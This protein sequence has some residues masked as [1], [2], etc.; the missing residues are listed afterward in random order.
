MADII[1]D[2][3]GAKFT[4]DTDEAQKSIQKLSSSINGLDRALKLV[5]FGVFLKGIKS[6]ASAGYKA[7]TQMNNYIETMNLFRATMGNSTQAATEF[8]NKA[9]KVLGLDSSMTMNS[10]AMLQTLAE[11][12]GLANEEAYIMSQNLTQLAAD[13]SSFLNISFEESLGKLKSGLAGEVKAMRNVGVALDRATLQETMYRLGIDQTYASLTRAQKTEL[14]YYQIM[15]STTKMQGDLARTM[16]SPQNAIRILQ[17][18][19]TRLA[20]AIG[21]IF[22][23]IALKIIPVVRAVTQILIEA[24]Q[25]LAKF[26]GFN[27]GD[28]ESDISNVG[29]LLS[30]ISDDIDDVGTS[31]GKAAKELN[32]MLM[33]FDELNNITL[34]SPSAGGIGGTGVGGIGG[35]L[36]IPLPEY[37]MFAGASDE[38]AKKIENI[39]TKIKEL[40]GL[41]G[42]LALA[43]ANV[44]VIKKIIDVIGAINNAKKALELFSKTFPGLSKALRIGTGLVLAIE[45]VWVEYNYAKKLIQG[46]LSIGTLLM[47]T[48]N[49]LLAGIGAALLTGSGEIGLIAGA[50]VL[51]LNLGLAI[52]VKLTENEDFMEV[53]DQVLKYFNPVEWG[54]SLG[55]WIQKDETLDQLNEIANWINNHFNPIMWGYNFTEWI[56]NTDTRQKLEDIHTFLYTYFR[57]YQW[58]YDFT[59]WIRNTDARQ[60][61]ED[62]HTFLYNNFQPYQWGYDFTEW[63]KQDETQ[64]KL[65]EIITFINNTFNPLMWGYNFGEWVKKPETQQKLSEIADWINNHF[66]PFMWGYNLVQWIREGDFFNTASRVVN[67]IIEWFNPW[68]WGINIANWFQNQFNNIKLPHFRFV[69]EPAP[70]WIG[71]VLGFFGL[72]KTIPKLKI[73]WYEE[74]GFPDAG[75]LFFANE[76]GNAELIGNIGNRTAVANNDQI[77]EGIA[78][79]TYNAFVRALS[80]NKQSKEPQTIVVNLGNDKLYEGFGQYQDDMSNMYGITI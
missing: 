37:D 69:G 43:F 32:K 56:R 15:T 76:N 40:L 11:G 19:F 9:E 25:A 28:F 12:Y 21:S 47:G 68:N 20:R 4:A 52:G 70:E 73:D 18:E 58:G 79:A 5:G 62:I 41:L 60:K 26:F 71:N 42:P 2:S 63:I 55:D 51:G 57:P 74:G 30:G 46:D 29:G 27:L 59:E 48:G 66:N 31:A 1:T 24:A 3:V 10:I 64:Q 67:T 49:A 8:V 35:S 23:P 53:Y 78:A 75:Q 22:I 54:M 17:Q 36:G 13:M 80:E 45:S 39:K 72:P 14:I 77:T 38:M 34:E 61:L 16:I 50:G 7:M 6:I 44:W 33:P 65:D